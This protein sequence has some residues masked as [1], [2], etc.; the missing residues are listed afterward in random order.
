[1]MARMD[2]R[3]RELERAARAGDLDAR[4]G[5]LLARMR[6]GELAAERVELAARL[7]DAGARAVLGLPDRRVPPRRALLDLPPPALVRALVLAGRSVAGSPTEAAQL[8]AAAAWCDCPCPDH[9]ARAYQASRALPEGSVEPSL[10]YYAAMAAHT[11]GRGGAGGP[12]SL[13]SLAKIALRAA[14][15]VE[16]VRADVIAWALAGSR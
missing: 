10:P 4:A 5:L 2:L 1:M 6:A 8:E 3:W 14:R 7:G 16:R 11:A 15:D 13:A 9:A 12:R